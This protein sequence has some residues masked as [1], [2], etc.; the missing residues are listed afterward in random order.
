MQAFIDG[1]KIVQGKMLEGS[2]KS[3]EEVLMN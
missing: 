2:H 1:L 3:S